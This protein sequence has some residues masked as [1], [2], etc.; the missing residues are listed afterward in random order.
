MTVLGMLLSVGMMVASSPRPAEVAVSKSLLLDG[1]P[2]A[3][4]AAGKARPG[5]RL[6][7][8]GALGEADKLAAMTSCLQRCAGDVEITDDGTDSG[9]VGHC[10]AACMKL[11]PNTFAPSPPPARPQPAT[12]SLLVD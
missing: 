12:P 11:M 6:P 9:S 5:R 10:R 1:A 2:P 8:T 7:R 4:S 3:V